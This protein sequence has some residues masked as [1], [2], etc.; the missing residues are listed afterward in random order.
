MK[1]LLLK[2][3]TLLHLMFVLFVVFTPFLD[4]NYFLMLHFIM[5]PFVMFHWVCNDNTC[6]LTTVERSLRKEISGEEY[7]ENDCI[8]C[9]LIE[10]VYDFK[11][12][13]ESQSKLIYLI[14]FT[15]WAI[16]ISKLYCKYRFGIITRFMDLFKI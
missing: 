16:T 12:N 8:T 7:K 10:P 5:I 14:T 11:N 1:E 13:F 15:L 2:I 4:S 6:M 3:I 9:K